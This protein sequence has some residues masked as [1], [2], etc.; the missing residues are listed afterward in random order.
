MYTCIE[1]VF[2][3]VNIVVSY[4]V[5]ESIEILGS[6]NN[7][8]FLTK[9]VAHCHLT[10]IKKAETKPI[11]VQETSGS[12]NEADFQSSSFWISHIDIWELWSYCTVVDQVSYWN[13]NRLYFCNSRYFG[14]IA[15]RLGRRYRI[16]RSSQ[17]TYLYQPTT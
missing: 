13:I 3:C 8:S 1:Y 12:C 9:R 2:N 6:I 4:Y 11:S 7:F 10:P 15:S 5:C 14:F 16:L 17:L